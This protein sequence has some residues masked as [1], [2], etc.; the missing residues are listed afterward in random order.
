M[1]KNAMKMNLE[2]LWP[3]LVAEGG[4]FLVYEL[5]EAILLLAVKLD[6]SGAICGVVLLAVGVMMNLFAG[7]GY[8][9]INVDQI[10]R[11]HV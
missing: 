8:P 9:L 1:L 7:C 6:I 5:I 11:A 2:D 4:V 3:F 10:G